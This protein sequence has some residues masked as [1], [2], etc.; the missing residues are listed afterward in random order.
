ML[1]LLFLKT[2]ILIRNCYNDTF[3][4]IIYATFV[5]RREVYVSNI[6]TLFNQLSRLIYKIAKNSLSIILIKRLSLI[7]IFYINN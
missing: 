7:Y 3:I 2:T 1:F 6:F 4:S 5:S